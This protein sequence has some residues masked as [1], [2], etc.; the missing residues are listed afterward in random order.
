MRYNICEGDAVKLGDYG[1]IHVG[2]DGH[3][4]SGIAIYHNTFIT[5]PS[6]RTVVSLHGKDVGVAFRNNLI[7]APAGCPLVM[8]DHD[9][10]AII[11][12]G[13]L[14]WA[15]GRPF[16]T[17]GSKTCDSLEAW[18]KTGKETIDG[19]AVGLF[20]D[21]RLDLTVPRGQA[22]DLTW[23]AVLTRFQPLAESPAVNAGIDLKAVF[24]LD[25]GGLDFLKRKTQAGNAPDIGAI[26]RQ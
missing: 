12:Q 11:F 4:M 19:K 14:Y 6:A 26:E 16:K 9:A 8:I 13:N 18:R 3:G 21:P 1:A 20:A 23:P 24:K 22:G 5:G 17:S 10:E 25:H 2:N 7:L 15:G